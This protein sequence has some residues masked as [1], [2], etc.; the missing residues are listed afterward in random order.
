VIVSDVGAPVGRRG[1]E[2][3]LLRGVEVGLAGWE[4]AHSHGQGTGVEVREGI[5]YA[6]SAVNQELQNQGIEATIRELYVNK[7]PDVTLRM[8][9]ETKAY[10][11]T[12]RLQSIHYRVTAVR[13]QSQSIVFEGSIEVSDTRVN[14]KVS[15]RAEFP[16]K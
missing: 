5:L 13:G 11:G 15:A 14:P 1:Y 9:T 16:T 4:R 2:R 10:P 8:T 7:P 12:L 6:P 3:Q